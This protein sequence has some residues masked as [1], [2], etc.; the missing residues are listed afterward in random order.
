MILP[1][2][3]TKDQG[4][5]HIAYG[6]VHLGKVNSYNHWLTKIFA[7]I[8]QVFG[9]SKLVTI[10]NKVH[11]FEKK[12]YCDFLSTLGIKASLLP[13]DLDQIKEQIKFPETIGYM[14]ESLSTEK[15]Q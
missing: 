15:S 13:S 7:F 12:S 11:Y 2:F 14:R 10:N 4:V 1:L 5:T 3:A 9:T 6:N 8:G